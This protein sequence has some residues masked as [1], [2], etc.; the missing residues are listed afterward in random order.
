MKSDPVAKAIAWLSERRDLGAELAEAA[1]NQ[2]M[3]GEAT[4]VQMGALLVGLRT[5]GE[6]APELVGAVRA[7]RA[8]MVRL[9]PAP[10]AAVVDTCGTGGGQVTTFNISTA[11]AVVA[12]GAGVRV[13]K[14]G[15]RSFTSRCGSADVLE[16][17]GVKLPTNAAEAGAMLDGSGMTFLFAPLFHPA[18]KHIGPVRRELAITTM[19]NLLGPLA[20]PAGVSRQLVGVADRA[21][22]PLLADALSALGAEHAVVVHAE[23]GMDELSPV[24]LSEVWEVHDGSVR[25]WRLDPA[26]LGV[27]PGPLE[28]LRGASPEENAMLIRGVVEGRD[29]S[30]RREAVVLN[31]AGALVVAGKASS[32]A[33]G[34][35]AA[36]AAIDDGAAARVLRR[37]VAA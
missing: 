28:D 5:K 19:M 30:L 3:R 23:V 1:F 32:W 29:R 9:E 22:G 25:H 11:A 17:L 18:M 24:G 4:P 12:A 15:N 26:E 13:A 36:A 21:R 20:N 14:H 27:K 33:E 31:A 34:L 7:L 8:A 35:Q 37:L 10:G 6:T 16:A 2:V